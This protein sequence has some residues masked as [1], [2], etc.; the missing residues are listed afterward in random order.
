[1]GTVY[2]EVQ[3]WSRLTHMAYVYLINKQIWDSRLGGTAI[4]RITNANKGRKLAKV[5]S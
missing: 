1:M 4:S 2:G 3:S 5:S